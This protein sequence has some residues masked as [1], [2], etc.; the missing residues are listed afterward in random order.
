MNVYI[1]AMPQQAYLNPVVWG[2]G[3]PSDIAVWA[4]SFI[5]VEDKFRTLFAMLFGAGAYMMLARDEANKYRKHLAR[6]AVLFLF[7]LVHAVVLANND[8]L[9]GYALAG[10][11]LPLFMNLSP[12]LLSAGAAMLLAV[13]LAGAMVTMGGISPYAEQIW[14][15]PPS[16]PAILSFAE[17]NYGSDPDAIAAS[18]Q[19]GEESLSERIIRRT[20]RIPATTTFVLASVPLNLAAMLVGILLWKTGLLSGHWP[21]TKLHKLAVRLSLV[22]LAPLLLLA[23]MAVTSDFSALVMGVNGL[24]LSEPFDLLLGTAYAALAMA[25]FQQADEGRRWFLRLA[26]AG[27]MSL[28]NYLM[29]SLVLAWLFASWGLGWFGNIDRLQALAIAFL[30]IALILLWSK[31]WLARFRFG[32]FEWLWRTLARGQLQDMKRASA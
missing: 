15:E 1:F 9:R 3:D 5:L 26:A 17:Q 27:R 32:P 14:H 8:I 12:R 10:L 22:A 30:P 20:A 11:L 25:L 16:N 23:W 21:V 19:R 13:H 4:F 31:A 18:V 7:G 6:M 24:F 2:G 29:T 28:T